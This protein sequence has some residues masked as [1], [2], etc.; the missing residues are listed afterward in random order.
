MAALRLQVGDDGDIAGAERPRFEVQL[1]ALHAFAAVAEGGEGRDG[2][3]WPLG[4]AWR[5]RGGMRSIG[6]WQTTLGVP[7]YAWT[8]DLAARA[9]DALGAAQRLGL[10]MAEARRAAIF[11]RVVLRGLLISE[12]WLTGEPTADRD[13]DGDGVPGVGAEPPDGAA[14]VFRRLVTF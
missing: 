14:P 8:P 2:P 3:P 11:D 4:S 6:T 9:I 13:G 12:T 7:A 1:A 5:R 10:P